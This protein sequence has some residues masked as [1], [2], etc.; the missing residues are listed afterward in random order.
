ME[1]FVDH[2]I[3]MGLPSGEQGE[4]LSE[5]EI[6]KAYRSKVKKSHPDKR[7]D[8][9]NAH[10]NFLNLHASYTILMDKK[11]RH[12]FHIEAAKKQIKRMSRKSQQQNSSNSK[13]RRNTTDVDEREKAARTTHSAAQ[14][15]RDNEESIRIRNDQL[16]ARIKREAAACKAPPAPSTSNKG[17]PPKEAAKEAASTQCP[18]GQ[19]DWEFSSNC[20]SRGDWYDAYENYVLTKPHKV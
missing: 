20:A 10:R 2:Y 8:D 6:K 18:F 1:G 15:D 11:A 9:P 13:R 4:K 16:I 3:I 17:G 19:G 5:E 12:N 14:S 7:P